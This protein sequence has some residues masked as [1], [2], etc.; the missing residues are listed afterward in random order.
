MSDTP[1]AARPSAGI[2]SRIAAAASLNRLAHALLT[3]SGEEHKVAEIASLADRLAREIEAMPLRDRFKD[4]DAAPQF[5]EVLLN[6]PDASLVADGEQVDVFRDSPVSGPF[7][8]L[9]IGMVIHRDGD[10]A[11]GVV[12]LGRGF[13]GA[14]DRSHGGIVAA[15]VDEAMGCLLPIIGTMAF[16]GGL[17]LTY[18]A[19]CPIGVPIEFRASLVSRD[20]RKL[21]LKCVGTGPDGVFVESTAVFIAMAIE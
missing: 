11:V 9:S 17:N 8:P 5:M 4:T 20:G 7:N 6:S 14:P 2:E 21:N 3:H 10:E 1:S 13:E 19:G 16:T 12:T 15:C 18:K